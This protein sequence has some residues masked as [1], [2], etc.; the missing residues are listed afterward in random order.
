MITHDYRIIFVEST[1]GPSVLGIQRDSSF[2]NPPG[3]GV[4]PARSAASFQ[5]FDH[6]LNIVFIFTDGTRHNF[7]I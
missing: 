5:V 6:D 4:A 3:H 7:A 2:T 1:Y